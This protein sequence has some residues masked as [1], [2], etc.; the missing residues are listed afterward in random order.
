MRPDTKEVWQA[1]RKRLA[2]KPVAG[3]QALKK[4]CPAPSSSTRGA[5]LAPIFSISSTT[6]TK[7]MVVTS[8][9]D[10]VVVEPLPRTMRSLVSCLQSSQLVHRLVLPLL[11]F[12]LIEEK[13]HRVPLGLKEPLELLKSSNLYRHE[14]LFRWF[15]ISESWTSS[16]T[17]ESCHLPKRLEG[18]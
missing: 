9:I 15:K 16:S 5:S 12:M 18:Y 3:S 17:N 1:I 8:T 2:K 6:G 13:C 11:V 14:C 4:P 10:V 7:A